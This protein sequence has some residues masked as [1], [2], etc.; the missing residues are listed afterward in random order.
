[1][2]VSFGNLPQVV[3]SSVFLLTSFWAEFRYWGVSMLRWTWV[4]CPP[5]SWRR[6]RTFDGSLSTAPLERKIKGLLPESGAGSRAGENH[7]GP[8]SLPPFKLAVR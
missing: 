1:M 3:V 5:T 8:L 4:P 2:T 7:P 6:E